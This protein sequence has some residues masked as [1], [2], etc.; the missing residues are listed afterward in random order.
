MND[1][2]KRKPE[3][4]AYWLI[5]AGLVCGL[6]AAFQ[7]VT[8]SK[9]DHFRF[10]EGHHP[11]A[12]GV[13]VL[14]SHTY[15]VKGFTDEYLIYSWK[16]NYNDAVRRIGEELRS[17]GFTRPAPLSKD[18]SFH[19][20]GRSSDGYSFWCQSGLTRSRSDAIRNVNHDANHITVMTFKPIPDNWISHLRYSIEPND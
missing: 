9:P 13:N 19:A 2:A 18:L 8:S 15:Q 4:I 17:Q 6:L 11:L 14:T 20:W 16:E 3:K 10:L 1:V 7:I 12:S 5:A